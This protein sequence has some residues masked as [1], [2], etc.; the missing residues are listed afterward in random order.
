M[1]HSE[2]YKAK[3]LARKQRFMQQAKKNNVFKARRRNNFSRRPNY[4][5]GPQNENS[6]EK[7]PKQDS[8]A[9]RQRGFFQV[10]PTDDLP[11][12]PE[13]SHGPCLLFEKKN[14]PE[15]EE[16]F[17]SCAIYRNQDEFCDFKLQYNK[18]T[19]EIEVKEGEDSEKKK[20]KK[21]IFGYNRIPKA[22]TEMKPT[23]TVLYCKDCIN[24]F[25][26]KHE[27]VCEPVEKETLAK[28]TN[29]L[30]PVSEQHGESQFFFSEETLGVIVRAVEK[31][32]VDGILCIGAPRIFENI[33][34]RHPE[35]NVFLLDYDKRF[36]KFFP[37]KQYAQYSM[38]VDHFFDKNAEPKLM[39]FFQNSKSVLLI[40]DPPFGVFMEPLLKTIEKMKQRF[41]TTGKEI[42]SFYSMIVLPIYIRKYVL[43]DNF[44]MSDYRVTYV[45][46]KL[47][48]YP[49]KTIVRLFTNLPKNCIDLEKVDGYKFCESCDR[50]VTK[51]NIHCER[52]DACT[53]VE[54]G[55][56]NHCDQ[57]D[58]CVKPRYVHCAECERCHLYGRCIQ[59]Y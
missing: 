8:T 32:K 39:E 13:C 30:P 22:L 3:R 41:V 35:K 43:H 14:G 7:A 36:A 38:L 20:K 29:L 24:V 15:V 18:E 57:C 26:N 56:W 51:N 49:E 59:K 47:Y 2:E 37:S 1:V 21:K 48:Q 12:V 23:D 40:T 42:T 53:S 50:Y 44:W 6:Y 33:R 27:C 31:S 46:H 25:A 58:K 5:N 34:A 45:G 17:F 4:H 28:P 16:T 19:G 11:S 54:Q 55:K 9:L 10:L 52:C